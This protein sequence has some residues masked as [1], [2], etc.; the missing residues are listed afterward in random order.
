[1]HASLNST[2]LAPKKANLMALMVRGLAVPTAIELLRKTHKKS[3]RLFEGIILSAVANASHNF[4]QDAQMMVVKEVIVN[5]GTSLRRGVPMARGR[6]RPIRKFM[7]HISITLGF[8]N[9]EKPKA[10][11][12]QKKS[13][14]KQETQS[15]SIA[16]KTT[17]TRTK[18]AET[19]TSS[20]NPQ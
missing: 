10:V 8:V 3:A 16:K 11:T 20:S 7:S 14:T 2:R 1:M 13:T 5:Q 4:K 9:L 15:S 19:S 18:S 6:V 12:A 17:S